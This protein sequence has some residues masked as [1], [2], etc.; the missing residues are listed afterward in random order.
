MMDEWQRRMKEEKEKERLKQKESAEMLQGYRGNDIREADR[1][2][3]AMKEEERKKQQETAKILQGY[4]SSG[5]SEEERKLKAMKEEERKKQQEAESLLHSFKKTEEPDAKARPQRREEHTYPEPVNKSPLQQNDITYISPGSVAERKK[6][7]S[8][9][10]QPSVNDLTA[11]PN[12]KSLKGVPLLEVVGEEAIHG[13]TNQHIEN[14]GDATKVLE[15]D[16]ENYPLQDVDAETEATGIAQAEKSSAIQSTLEDANNDK[17]DS[18]QNAAQEMP[19]DFIAA[20]PVEDRFDV[21]F[22]F[23]I[24]TDKGNPTLGT[25]MSAVSEVIQK[26]IPRE[27]S[28]MKIRFDPSYQPYVVDEKLDSNYVD[29]RNRPDIRRLIITAAVP[30]MLSAG[31]SKEQAQQVATS[32]LADAI[33]SQTFLDLLGKK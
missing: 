5:I 1:K 26:K 2:L 17:S 14:V 31:V 29:T 23:G 28:T 3:K 25:Y 24:I 18:V 11:S 10:Y 15:P 16:S 8:S 32:A 7:F 9:Q 27:D 19:N 4:R 13:N 22:S 20:E 33:R 12:S 30:L 6:S 21:F